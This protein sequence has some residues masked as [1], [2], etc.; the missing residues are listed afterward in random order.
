MSG[1]RNGQL[2]ILHVYPTS[3]ERDLKQC[4]NYRT[5]AV[6]SHASK[7][8]LWIILERIQMKTKTEIADE[9]AGFYRCSM[10]LI[11]LKAPVSHNQI[12]RPISTWCWLVLDRQLT[13]DRVCDWCISHTHTC[14]TQNICVK[15]Y[16]IQQ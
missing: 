11:V 7:I 4:R 12:N 5:I 8:L 1:Q 9:Q 10:L 13:N 15:A 6:V 16:I 2:D 14:H 3:Q